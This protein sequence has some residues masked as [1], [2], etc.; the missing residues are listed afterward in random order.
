MNTRKLA[1]MAV[2]VA[3]ASAVHFL[4]GLLPPLIPALP[5]A[6]L[7]LANVFSLFTLL[8]Y[9]AKGALAVVLLRCLVGTLL[10]AGAPSGLIYSLA[11]GLAS[12]A[13]MAL[14]NRLFGERAGTVG[15]SVAGAAMHNTGQILAAVIM[16]GSRYIFAYLPWMLLLAIPTGIFVGLL[17]GLCIKA[18]GG[19]R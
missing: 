10:I 11:G 4:E 1:Y 9:S 15:L 14:I 12:W 2:I 8:I 6:K 17:C 19:M 5:G 16:L 7:G 18:I 13:V 3:M